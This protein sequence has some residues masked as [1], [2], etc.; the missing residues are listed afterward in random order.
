MVG[1]PQAQQSGTRIPRRATATVVGITTL[2]QALAT[3]CT[4]V[5]AAIAPELARAFGVPSSMIGYQVSLIYLGAILTSLV[6]AGLIL[7]LGALRT[8][9]MALA[10][11]GSGLALSA[12]PSMIAF[13]VG[14]VMVGFGYGLTNPSA[15]H[16]LI[17]V[18][19]PESRNFIFSLK[20]TGVPLGAVAA[21]LAAPSL[22]LEFGWQWA[23]LIIAAVP[24]AMIVVV[25]PFHAGWD[26]DRDRTATL[27]KNPVRDL[28]MIWRHPALKLIS[29]AAFCFSAVQVSLSTFAVT[30]LVEDLA[31]GLVQ[32]GIVL[33]ALQA[34]GALGRVTWGG[35]ADRLSDGNRVLAGVALIAVIAGL[36]TM[37]LQ[38]GGP[39][40]LVYTV[41][42][43]FGLSAIGWNG[44]FLA[45][46]AR[47]AP[48]GMASNATGGAMVP[49][50]SGVL[51]GPAS[52]AVLYGLTGLYTVTFGLFAAV[53]LIGFVLVLGAR[54]REA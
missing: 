7:R 49:T 31:Y 28:D 14:S 1:E 10:F 30:M 17:R 11:A 21:G 34:A 13:A 26:Q 32:A 36:L 43:L 29:L 8:S 38:P 44:V 53:S 54:R 23:F 19:R 4:L 42:C 15:T 5:P 41:L 3:L 20:Q 16:L 2:V 47:L 27:R 50:Y 33:S 25:Q 39:I 12:V 6:S 48:D 22:S 46:V 37:V 24:L 51:V 18:S 52:F 45:E 9:Q 35:V 40:V